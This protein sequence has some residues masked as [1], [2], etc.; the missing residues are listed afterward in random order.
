LA[1]YR[2]GLSDS[3]LTGRTFASHDSVVA[4]DEGAT[5]AR[6][7]GA[8][9]LCPAAPDA[10]LVGGAAQ[11]ALGDARASAE[12]TRYVGAGRLARCLRAICERRS[13]VAGILGRGWCLGGVGHQR[14]R[15]VAAIVTLTSALRRSVDRGGVAGYEWRISRAR[16]VSGSEGSSAV[17]M[18]RHSCCA[19]GPSRL[20]VEM[21]S[22]VEARAREPRHRA[23]CGHDAWSNQNPTL[24]PSSAVAWEGGIVATFS[25]AT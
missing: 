13:A 10:G 23:E 5:A 1:G 9:A 2:T 16:S 17:G 8:V 12:W 15:A 6:R 21:E 19:P 20:R 24:R 3:D 7:A 25:P 18:S 22:S 14:Q 4:R 11:V